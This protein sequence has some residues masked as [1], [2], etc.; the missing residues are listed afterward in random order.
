MQKILIQNPDTFIAKV[1]DI[2]DLTF[3]TIGIPFLSKL[4]ENAIVDKVNKNERF[5]VLHS[6]STNGKLVIRV[7]IVINPFPIAVAISAIT[8]SVIGLFIFLSLSKVEQIINTPEG[9]TNNLA[10]T[11]GIFGAIILLGTTILKKG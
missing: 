6:S 3:N 4:Q 5:S 8:T 7:K 9:K 11:V 10:S 2:Y 1:G